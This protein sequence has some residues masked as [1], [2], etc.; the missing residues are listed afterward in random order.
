MLPKPEIFG[1]T[2]E[3]YPLWHF[4]AIFI[5]TTFAYI[6]F[7]KEIKRELGSKGMFLTMAVLILGGYLGAKIFAIF[8]AWTFT[9]NIVVTDFFDSWRQSYDLRWYGSLL[10]IFAATSFVLH[11]PSLR[12][13]V[14]LFDGVAICLALFIGI[15][16]LA[17]LFSGDSCQGT[18][19]ALPWGMHFPYGVAPRILPVHP[20][21]LYDFIFHFLL[22]LSFLKFFKHKSFEG[23]VGLIFYLATSIFNVG[24][25]II[26]I[27]PAIIGGLTLAQCTYVIIGGFAILQYAVIL[28]KKHGSLFQTMQNQ[29]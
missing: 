17:C 27:N 28:Y 21:S 1:V 25:E 20:T 14:K 2:I 12:K 23:Q 22:F 13:Y 29:L 7:R 18:I 5:T 10:F 15:V 3:W 9:G 16:K 19:T 11:F 4:L 8:Y 24:L 26:R 6:Y